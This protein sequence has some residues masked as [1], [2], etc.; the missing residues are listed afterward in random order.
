[1]SK[2]GQVE[3]ATQKG[4]ITIRPAEV[5]DAEELIK[6]IGKVERQ[7]DFLLREPDEFTL[8]IEQEEKLIWSQLDSEVDVML[9]AKTDGKIVGICSLNGN[10]RKRI[11]HCAKFAIA[12]DIEY[13]GMGIGK[14]MMEACINW[15]RENRISRITLE[16][17]TNNYGAISLYMKLGFEIEGTFKND[18]LLP[19][20]S[21]TNG[22]AMALLLS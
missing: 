1:M 8:T 7:T 2:L 17:D 18:K 19:D 13:S 14:K 22:Y 4:I 20:G 6:L 11:R 12:V 5:K 3:Y 16:V 10:A 21:Y 15:A 9:I